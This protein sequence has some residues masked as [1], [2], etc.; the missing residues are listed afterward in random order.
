M[1]QIMFYDQLPTSDTIHKWTRAPE[2]ALFHWCIHRCGT[3]TL[4]RTPSVQPWNWCVKSCFIINCQLLTPFTRGLWLQKWAR[5][6]SMSPKMWNPDTGAD[7][8]CM[9]IDQ[10]VKSCFI[11]NCQLLTPFTSGLWLQKWSSSTP[12]P[13]P[14]WNP[15]NGAEPSVQPLNRCVNSCFIINYQ[16]L[17][18]FTS[19]LGSRSGPVPN[20]CP[21]RCGTRPQG[22]TPSVWPWNRCVKLCFIINCQLL[23]PFTSGPWLQ[24]WAWRCGTRTLGRTPSVQPWNWCVKSCFIINCQ[25]LTLFISGLGFQKWARSTSMPPQMW[26][27]DTGAGRNQVSGYRTDVSNSVL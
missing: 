20:Q 11:I 2:V 25:L 17:T 14:M 7:T 8:K 3:R 9:A 5:S 1:C 4:G 12:V 23:T 26:N 15:D 19:G 18:L 16:L 21:H 6:T 24:K 10:C 22:L 27:P 13:S